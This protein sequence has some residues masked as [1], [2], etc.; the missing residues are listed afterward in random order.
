MQLT[1]PCGGLGLKSREKGGA[2]GVG[3]EEVEE[4]SATKEEKRRKKRRGK[5]L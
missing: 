4:L 5:D 2:S 1:S 3:L